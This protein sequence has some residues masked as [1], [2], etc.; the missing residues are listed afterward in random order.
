MKLLVSTCL[1][2]EVA[3][4]V[5]YTKSVP[6]Y[7][8][9]GE[10]DADQCFEWLKGLRQLHQMPH[11]LQYI[12]IEQNVD[13]HLGIKE[14]REISRFVKQ[15][16]EHYESVEVIVFVQHDLSYGILRMFNSLFGILGAKPVMRL[17]RREDQAS[18]QLQKSI[19]KLTELNQASDPLVKDK[20][21]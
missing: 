20:V 17:Y 4:K 18:D 15:Q 12:H 7:L 2:K 21:S 1:G 5:I 9:E 19:E 8:I 10:V 16:T 11:A 3:I 14:I 13:W 6:T